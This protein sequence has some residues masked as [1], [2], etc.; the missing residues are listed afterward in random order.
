MPAVATALVVVTSFATSAVLNRLIRALDANSIVSLRR[1]FGLSFVSNIIWA[2]PLAAGSL[3]SA[4][5]HSHQPSLNEFVLGS[6]FAWSFDL[7]VINGVFVLSTLRSLLVAAT[8]PVA[9]VLVTL[10]LI[11]G[12]SRAELYSGVLGLAVLALTTVFLLKFKTFRTS[13]VGIGSLQTFQSFLKSWV[14]HD[15]TDLERYFTLY[16]HDKP[17]ETKIVLAGDAQTASLVLPGVH[18][19][20]FFPVGSYNLSELIFQELGRRKMVPMV[21]HGVGGHERNLPTNELTKRYAADIAATASQSPAPDARFTTMRGPIAQTIG[22]TTVTAF[23]FGTQVVAFLTNAPKDTDD[24]EPRT[25]DIAEA[26]AA[27]RGVDLALVDAHNSIGGGGGAQPRLELEDWRRVVATILSDTEEE[28]EVATAHSSEIQFDHGSDISDGGIAVLLFRRRA[29]TRALVT[30]DSNNALVGL[31]RRLAENLKGDGVGLI[32][33][34]TSDTHK[35]AATNLIARGYR[36]LGEDTPPEAV[37][38]AVQ[39]LTR[40]ALRRLSP[41]RAA[42]LTSRSTLPLVGDQS[43]NDFAALTKEAV[44]FAKSY[45]RAAFPAII[46][47]G[48]FALFV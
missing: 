29:E 7:L 45:A 37:A 32:E 2:L 8:Q 3:Y 43:L 40:L 16:S 26:A 19:G 21:L 38:S 10:A 23:A 5:A 24:L 18:P 22:E 41:G 39:E 13:E 9:M 1:I 46:L 6:I 44:G 17:V 27:E 34:C 12:P 11:T 47:I 35:S 31:R 36:A 33:L 20:P 14:S 4:A 15:P 48:S 28:F 25:I 42:V 30:S